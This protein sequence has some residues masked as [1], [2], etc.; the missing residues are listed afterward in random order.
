MTTKYYCNRYER[1]VEVYDHHCL[2]CSLYPFNV[3]ECP[4]RTELQ[5]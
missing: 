1:E 2:G 4:Y 3:G 5:K